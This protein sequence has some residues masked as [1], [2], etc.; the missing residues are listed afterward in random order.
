M[1]K[2]CFGGSFNPIHHGHL[3]CA[4]AVAEVAGF[5]RVVLIPSAQPPHKPYVEDLAEPAHRVQMCRLATEGDE[6]FEIDELEITRA[7]LSYTLYTAREFRERGWDRVNWLIGADMLNDLPNWHEPLRL[8]DEVNFVVMARP[9]RTLDWQTL[10]AEYRALR[11]RVMQA[12]L[13]DISASEIRHR[14]KAG[15]PISYLVPLPVEEYIRLHGLYLPAKT[16][17][18]GKGS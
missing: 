9:G 8:L 2:L 18:K 1:A 17:S 11:A 10:P 14:V 7:G 13:I 12:P 16:N 6:L 5:D 15:K 4:R 3:I